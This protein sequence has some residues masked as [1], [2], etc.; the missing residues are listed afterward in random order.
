ML[1][2]EE[3]AATLHSM[4]L[5]TLYVHAW[6]LV[7]QTFWNILFAVSR[8]RYIVRQHFAWRNTHSTRCKNIANVTFHKSL[9]IKHMK[10]TISKNKPFFVHLL[11][12]SV[13]TDS[14]LFFSEVHQSSFYCVCRT[15]LRSRFWW[16]LMPTLNGVGINCQPH[17]IPPFDT[18]AHCLQHMV[19]LNS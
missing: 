15:S 1:L 10:K 14:P 8:P 4:R 13:M 17:H 16:Q 9:I 7:H 3:I 12:I 6:G 5:V 2:W 19:F 11:V 18:F